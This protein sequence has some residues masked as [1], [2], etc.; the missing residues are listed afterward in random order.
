MAAGTALSESAIGRR[1][2]IDVAPWVHLTSI[3][4]LSES[5]RFTTSF[6][7]LR[8]MARTESCPGSPLRLTIT[9]QRSSV[10][11]PGSTSTSTDVTPSRPDRYLRTFL[12]FLLRA[13]AKGEHPPTP[14]ARDTAPSASTSRRRIL[15]NLTPLPFIM[16]ACARQAKTPSGPYP[17]RMPR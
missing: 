4:T 1:Q 17:L 8:M 10:T 16:L 3:S 7:A 12:F 2:D 14:K 6:R 9:S 15:I 11:S 13:R 5:A